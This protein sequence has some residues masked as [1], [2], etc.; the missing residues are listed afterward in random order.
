MLPVVAI[1]TRSFPGGYKAP[2]AV[3]IPNSVVEILPEAFPYGTAIEKVTID[4]GDEPIILSYAYDGPMLSTGQTEGKGT[5]GY[6][7]LKEIYIGRNLDFSDYNTKRYG[8]T[9]FYRSGVKKVTFGTNVTVIP[10]NLFWDCPNLEELY[11]TDSIQEIGEA[12]FLFSPIETS[13]KVPSN[14]KIIPYGTFMYSHFSIIDLKSDLLVEIGNS[15]FKGQLNSYNAYQGEGSQ[16]LI[17]GKNLA[18][19]GQYAFSEQKNLKTITIFNETPPSL[20]FSDPTTLFP[21]K[22]YSDAV[23]YVPPQSIDLYKIANIWKYFWSIE[24][25]PNYDSGIT[26]VEV[27]DDVIS[28]F[29]IYD[30]N[31]IQ[32]PKIGH[33]INILK[34]RNGTTKK[35]IIN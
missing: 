31:G 29:I 32:V 34:Y 18:R 25:I 30:I 10:P 7:P 6:C 23:L 15:S 26:N 28:Q 19:I 9:P 24:P 22:V 35:I 20:E 16:S 11:L 8:Y 13:F 3:I 14:V 27:D 33:G 4:D 5:F 12:A 21:S 1:A 17:L 2:T